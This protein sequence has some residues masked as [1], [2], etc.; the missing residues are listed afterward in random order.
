MGDLRW[1]PR[2][3]VAAIIE[4]GGRF[5]LVEEQVGGELLLNNP[6]GHLEPGESLEQAVVR[7]VLEETARPFVPEA[8]LG[9]YLIERPGADGAALTYLRFAFTGR[10][11]EPLPGRTLDTPVV[12]THWLDADE[13]RRQADRHRSALVMRCVEDYQAGRRFPLEMLAMHAAD[14]SPA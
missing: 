8:L 2:V 1:T 3:T 5:L 6:A 4:H 9:V 7:E 11:G 13:V 10:V 14:R 12:A